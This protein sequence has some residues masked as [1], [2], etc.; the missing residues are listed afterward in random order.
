[1]KIDAVIAVKNEAFKL[2]YCCKELRKKVPISNLI[3]VVGKSEDKTLETANKYADILIEENNK[4]LGYARNQ[5]LKEVK[6]EYYASIDSDVIL[7]KEWYYWCKNTI[8]KPSVAACEGYPKPQGTYYSRFQYLGRKTY[9]SLGNTMLKTNVIREVGIPLGGWGEDHVLK[10]RLEAKGYEWIVSFD[11]I[12][13]HLV[14]DLEMLRHIVNFNVWVGKNQKISYF[15]LTKNTCWS[16]KDF[17][18]QATNLGLN[19][20]TYILL[21]RLAINLGLLQGNLNRNG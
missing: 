17:A 1:M 10:E 19:Q 6:T 4:G 12:S 21:Y 16:L 9:C 5:G 8:K 13:Q 11:L 7:S 2:G 15:N 3:I 14:T 18:D 20:S